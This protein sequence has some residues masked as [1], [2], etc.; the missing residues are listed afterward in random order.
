MFAMQEQVLATANPRSGPSQPID[1]RLRP[2]DHRL[3]RRWVVGQSGEMYHFDF[4]DALANRFSRCGL[5]FRPAAMAAASH[6]LCRGCCPC[7]RRREGAESPMWM[8]PSWLAPGIRVGCRAKRPDSVS[9]RYTSFER[10]DVVRSTF[11]FQERHARRE[12]MNYG[13]C[14]YIARLAAAAPVV[15]SWSRLS[16]RSRSRLSP[17]S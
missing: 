2:A 16:A 7:C 1:A 8:A 4:F 12:M 6:D 13:H 15:P 14:D 17:S 9:V 11:I 5:P 3:N 10:Q